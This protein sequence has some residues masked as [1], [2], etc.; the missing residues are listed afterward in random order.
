VRLA[1][2]VQ[3][4][5]AEALSATQAAHYDPAVLAAIQARAYTYH[6]YTQMFKINNASFSVEDG[7]LLAHLLGTP[8]RR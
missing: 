7:S 4:P 8:T 6:V 3:V 5:W 1:G 2:C